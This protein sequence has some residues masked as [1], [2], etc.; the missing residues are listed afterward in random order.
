MATIGSAGVTRAGG[1]T[2]YSSSNTTN[3]YIPVLFSKKVLRNFYETSSYPLIANTDYSGEI[4]GVGDSVI[5]RKAPTLTIS[6]YTV[7]GTLTYQQ[8]TSTAIELNI[9]SA[10]SWS[11]R[12][13]DIDELQSDLNLMNEFSAAAA[14][15]LDT[16]IDTDCLSVWSAGAAAANKGATAGAISGNIAL[17]TSGAGNGVAITGGESGNAVDFI[18]T[19]NQVLDEQNI[20]MENRWIVLPSWYITMLKTGVLRRAD[21]TGDSSG[22]IR[23]G[24]VGMIDKFMVIR[25]N[26]LPW[27]NT[28]KN[29]TIMFG[30]KEALTFAMQLTKSDTLQIQDS[31]G[32]YI[33]GLAVY[34]KAVVQPTALG[35]G[36]VHYGSN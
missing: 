13:D 23:S 26:N 1:Y 20:G 29:S 5:I 33:R 16:A 9:D 24:V 25:S 2:N 18:M 21:V 10:K 14:R 8:P 22:V 28:N 31:F 34:G 32:Q 4:K 36:I 7:G 35:V 6:N 15:D 19:A 30:S 12:I 27:D 11:F 3:N 17:G